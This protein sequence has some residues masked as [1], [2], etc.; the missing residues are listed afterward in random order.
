MNYVPETKEV[1]GDG[2]DRESLKEFK[3]H[4]YYPCDRGTI[5]GS[6]GSF[7]RYIH[8]KYGRPLEDKKPKTATRRQTTFSDTFASI[9]V[10]AFAFPQEN[11]EQGVEAR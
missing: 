10:G 6:A 2:N 3:K 5:F 11:A 9:A 8:P 7:K 4:S 1:P